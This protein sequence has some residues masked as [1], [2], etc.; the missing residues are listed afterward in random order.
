M[1]AT[2]PGL[3]RSS[4]PFSTWTSR[5]RLWLLGW[6]GWLVLSLLSAAQSAALLAHTGRAIYW[7]PVILSRLADWGTCGLFTPAFFWMVERFPVRG[8]CW[9]VN[10][11][12]HLAGSVMFPPFKVA[13]YAPLLHSIFPDFQRGFGSVLLANLCPDMLGYWSAVGVIHAIEYHR[14]SREREVESARLDGARRAAEL[15]T[16]RAQLQPH[17]LFNTLQSISTLIHR[18]PTAADR[19]LA[20][21]SDLLRVSLRHTAAQAVPLHDELVFLERYLAIMRVRFGDR[22]VIGVDAPEQLRDATVPSLVL[23]PLVENAIR[24]GMA[25]RLDC[26]HV[27]IRARRDGASL[28]LEVTDDGPGISS[29]GSD[30]GGNGIGLANTRERLAGLYGPGCGLEIS[31]NPG[32][33]TGM[34]QPGGV[35][36]MNP[37][38]ASGV[39][40]HGLTVRLTIP[41]RFGAT[42]APG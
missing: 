9:R 20:D 25:D 28:R 34:G 42:E 14:E 30:G 31:V 7:G 41:L 36:P 23:Q 35:S 17:F 40:P 6:G 39:G 8:R 22:L 37:G 2:T 38:S 13:L 5:W 21:L 18:D 33:G 1:A 27:T 4:S 19:M 32:T 16:L 11:L 29:T 26:G 15:E 24:H 12:R 10:V 3:T